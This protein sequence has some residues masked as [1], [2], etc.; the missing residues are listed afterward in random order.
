MH[1]ET[2]RSNEGG[3]FKGNRYTGSLASAK[4][5]E[6][7]ESFTAATAKATG[8][9]ERDEHIAEWIRLAEKN[10]KEV[11]GQV[12]PKPKGG[13]PEGGIRKAARELNIERK[14]AERATKVAALSDEAKQAA[15][16]LLRRREQIFLAHALP[17]LM[18]REAV[19]LEHRH[20]IMRALSGVL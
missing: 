7:K 19:P 2:K 11:L 5:A 12:D 8:K 9:A 13:R 14:D 10:D 17:S 4:S 15:R 1:P 18:R 6:A 20:F 3:G 16:R